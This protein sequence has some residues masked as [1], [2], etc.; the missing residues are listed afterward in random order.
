MSRRDDN[1]SRYLDLF[2]RIQQTDPDNLP[3]ILAPTIVFS[4]PFNELTGVPA[5]AALLRKT[6]ADVEAPRFTVL[7]R[8]WQGDT[9]YVKWQFG[10]KVPVLRTWQVEGMSEIVFDAEDRVCRHVDYWDAGEQF[11]GRLP[12]IGGIIRFLRRR[13]SVGG[14]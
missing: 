5:F 2:V 10:G 11:Y 1:A 6:K 3:D 9:L 12:L 14:Q 13:L 4:D 8:V 7:D